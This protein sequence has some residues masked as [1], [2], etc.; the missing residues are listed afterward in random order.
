MSNS[1]VIYSDLIQNKLDR[2]SVERS[3]RICSIGSKYLGNDKTRLYELIINDEII[4]AIDA[5][6]VNILSDSFIN[7]KVIK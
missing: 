6:I 1:Q 7:L 2:L 5:E 4:C 3:D